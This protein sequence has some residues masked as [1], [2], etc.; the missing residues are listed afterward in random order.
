MIR[1]VLDTNVLAPGFVSRASASS[2]LIALWFRGHFELAVS[3]HLLMELRNAYQDRYFRARVTVD[4]VDHIL[5][6]LRRNAIVTELP[7]T[8]S[9]V[10]SHPED[11]LVLATALSGRASYLVTQDR[12]LLTLGEYRGFRIVPPGRL[13]AILESNDDPGA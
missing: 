12:Q 8:V 9:G 10:A 3:E 11:N 4:E 2:R 5:R 6:I 7:E 13:L 1:V